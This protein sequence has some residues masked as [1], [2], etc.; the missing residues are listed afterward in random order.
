MAVAIFDHAPTAADLLQARLARGW[1][2]TASGLKGGD[3]ILGYAACT[4]T[5]EHRALKSGESQRDV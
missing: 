4:V 2:P 1:R 3:R 5:A